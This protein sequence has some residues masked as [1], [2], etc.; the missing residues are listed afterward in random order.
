[1]MSD[2]GTVTRAAAPTVAYVLALIA[3]ILVVLNGLLLVVTGVTLGVAIPGEGTVL[4][5][6]GVVV[7]LGMLYAAR[8]LGSHPSQHVGWGAAI[9]LGAVASLVLVGGGFLFGFILGLVSGIIAIAWK[10]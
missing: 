3:G 8:W 2:T 5:A 6:A 7:G 10:A 9:I 1:M 4:G